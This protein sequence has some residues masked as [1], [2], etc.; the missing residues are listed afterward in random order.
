MK[1]FII[2]LFLLSLYGCTINIYKYKDKKDFINKVSDGK[3]TKNDIIITDPLIITSFSLN[4]PL[5]GT[6]PHD[7][8]PYG[9]GHITF[10]SGFDSI[11]TMIGLD[12][13]KIYS[14]KTIKCFSSRVTPNNFLKKEGSLN[15]DE[16]INCL[17]LPKVDSVFLI[18]SFHFDYGM[19]GLPHSSN[20]HFN[21][22]VCLVRGNKILYYKRIYG[23]RAFAGGDKDFPVK[24]IVRVMKM[25]TDDLVKSLQ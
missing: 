18:F 17:N 9:R 16:F 10:P 15:T 11:I 5:W 13:N 24:Q 4:E 23:L 8:S 12:S 22:Q 19:G 7:F 20:N 1:N 21:G 6:K 3:V 14:F 2:I 25:L